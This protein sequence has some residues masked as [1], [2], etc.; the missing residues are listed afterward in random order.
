[1]SDRICLMNGGRIEQLGTPED[2]YFRPRSWFAADF[3]GESNFLKVRVE[4]TDGGSA[5]VSVAGQPAA[6]LIVPAAGHSAGGQASLMIR[7]E[8]LRVSREAPRSG[9]FL[10]ARLLESIFVGGITR[11]YV[12]LDGGGSLFALELTAPESDPMDGGDQVFVSWDS[13]RGVLLSASETK[14]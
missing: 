10:R 7:P 3:L 13:N 12:A 1:M 5:T 4:S 2:L 8:S 9:N 6:R 11:R 14:P